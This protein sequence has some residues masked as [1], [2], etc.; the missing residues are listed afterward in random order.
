MSYLKILNKFKGRKIPI[1]GDLILDKYVFGGVSRVS[2][3]APVPIL[4]EEREE[5]R[6][7]GAANVA[8]NIASLG[9]RPFLFGTRGYDNE[10][11]KLKELL[12]SAGVEFFPSYHGK[13][14]RKTR[15]VGPRGHQLLRSDRE[16]TTPKHLG[17]PALE[18]KLSESDLVVVSDYAKGVVTRELLGKL[19]QS[20]KK[21]L[22]DPAPTNVGIY[23][24]F[25]LI[26]PNEAEALEMAGV[27]EV[28]KAG[29]VLRRRYGSNVVVTRGGEGILVFPLKGEVV[30]VPATSREVYDVS[31]AGDTVVSAFALSMASGANLE[32][33]ANIANHAAGVV[34]EKI[35]TSRVGLSELERS[36]SGSEQKVKTKEELKDIL[37]RERT[38]GKKIVWTNGCFDLIHPGHVEYLEE[39]KSLGD[40][41]VV[42]LNSDRS[43]RRLKGQG[44]PKIQEQARA[45]VLSG[46][47]S[48]DYIVILFSL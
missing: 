16:D 8:V 20:G 31:G 47:E 25:F 35:G 32:E 5:F 23:K 18:K 36:L 37:D 29:N 34:V 45:K 11:E 19:E 22:C 14:T 39:A 41:L 48:V 28:R 40:V 30:N 1:A 6:P 46:F 12:D 33:A 9:G 3:E 21:I 38:R 44:R 26:T 7:G 4:K 2:P 42:G 10:G 15:F 43:V 13:T 17:H 27:D 24:K